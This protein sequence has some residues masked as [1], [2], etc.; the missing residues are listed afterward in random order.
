[1]KQTNSFFALNRCAGALL[2]ALLAGTVAIGGDARAQSSDNA[3]KAEISLYDPAGAYPEAANIHALSPATAALLQQ[4]SGV[5]QATDGSSTF[6]M[7][8]VADRVDFPTMKLAAYQASR[9]QR[10]KL[11]QIYHVEQSGDSRLDALVAI[12]SKDDDPNLS[13]T[14]E[15]STGGTHS[16]DLLIGEARR[17]RTTRLTFLHQLSGSDREGINA[18]I[19]G[20]RVV[21]GKQSGSLRAP[22]GPAP[23]SGDA[24]KAPSLPALPDKGAVQDAVKQNPQQ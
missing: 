14:L 20:A 4:L 8:I 11:A 24:G 23:Q 6:T 1:M 19:A 2:F 3:G 9:L 10:E 18:M 22:A 7:T 15:K 5:W 17:Q 12:S 21:T 13:F 16:F